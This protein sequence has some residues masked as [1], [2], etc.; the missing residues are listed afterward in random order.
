[1][2]RDS[3]EKIAEELSDNDLVLL[4]KGLINIERELK[5]SGGSVAGA[6]WVYG[7]IIKRSLDSD[8]RLADFGFKNCDNPYIPYGMSYYG[9]R[10]YKAFRRNQKI[11]AER[12]IQNE[13]I[14]SRILERVEGRREKR[15]IA[16]TELRKLSPEMRGKIRDEFATKY[17]DGTVEEKFILMVNN[18]KYPPE[19]YPTEWAIVTEED[20]KELPVILI[21]QLYDK[22]STK[23]K[24]HWKRLAKLLSK[25]DDGYEYE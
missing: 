10:S 4:Y 19:Y 3:W 1:M 12:R 16:I 17:S 9:E 2:N 8:N 25:Y 24:G 11:A 15:K 7:V 20:I 5:W 6:I 22:L 13:K 23:T 18:E 21:K 14:Q